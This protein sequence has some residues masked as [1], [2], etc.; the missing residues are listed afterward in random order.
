MRLIV[1]LSDANPAAQYDTSIAMV[2][3][4]EA[5]QSFDHYAARI[6]I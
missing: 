1:D 5:N 2:L 6:N 3:L 4:L